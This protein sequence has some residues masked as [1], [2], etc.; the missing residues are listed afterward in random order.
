MLAML[1]IGLALAAAAPP[2]ASTHAGWVK[3]AEGPV[4]GGELGSIFDVN[5]LRE[6]GTFRL[7]FSWRARKSL[8]LVES[9]DGIHWGPPV[10]VLGP[11]PASGWEDDIN[12]PAVLKRG[13]TY[14][15]WYTAQARGKSSLGYATSRDGI[16]WTRQSERPVLVAEQRWEKVAVMCPHVLWDEDARLY[17]M[18]YSGGAQREPDAI[19]YATSADGRTWSKDAANPIFQAERANPWEAAKV[20]GAQVVRLG[21]AYVMFYIGFADPHH[22]RI[23]LARSADGVHDWQRH[24]AN[25]IIAPTRR[26]WDGDAVYKPF[27]LYDGT[28]W[29]LWYNGRRGKLEQIGLAM[30]EG[31]DLG[32]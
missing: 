9:A 13:E 1:I 21:D 14:H 11:N 27:A 32:F 22:A 6:Q 31:E 7:W 4:L 30:H 15:L 19:G 3:R 17:R 23:G 10:L 28:R 16:T 26:G 8:A 2:P 29:L 12:R 18:W 25:P 5:V 20:S 24:G